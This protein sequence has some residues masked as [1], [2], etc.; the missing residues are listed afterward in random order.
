MPLIFICLFHSRKVP[1]AMPIAFM[2]QPVLE[3]PPFYP[4]ATSV[5]ISSCTAPTIS[6]LFHG[7]SVA[8]GGKNLV[9]HV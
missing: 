1:V 6:M 7:L 4:K 9:G 3:F 8:V 5:K 2:D